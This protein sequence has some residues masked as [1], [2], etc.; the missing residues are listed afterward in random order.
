[1]KEQEYRS[2]RI[3]SQ[4]MAKYSKILNPESKIATSCPST[5]LSPTLISVR[6]PLWQQKMC[7]RWH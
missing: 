5:A 4:Q 1:M 6:L 3:T 2:G 7:A